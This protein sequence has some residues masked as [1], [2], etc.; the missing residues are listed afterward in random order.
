MLCILLLGND[1]M[2]LNV[3][4]HTCGQVK[5]LKSNFTDIDVTNS[6]VCDHFNILIQWHIHLIH[7]AKKLIESM[8]LIL[9]T[10]LIISTVLLCIMG[11]YH[12][13]FFL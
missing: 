10:Q 9:L 7:V 2:F 8:K 1:I 6:K 3:I 11:E 5:I 13:A 4:L 12:A